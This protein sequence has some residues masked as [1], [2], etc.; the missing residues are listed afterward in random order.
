[1]KN[2]YLLPTEEP[3]RLFFADEGRELNLSKRANLYS[4]G[5]HL[6]ITS[7]EYIGLSY[8]LDDNLVRKGV[9]DD[10]RYWEVRK[11]Y[12]KIILTTDPKLIKDGVQAIDDEFLE[13]FVKNLSCEYV[14]VMDL[15]KDGE[16]SRHD[17]YQIIIS[18]ED[19]SDDEEEPKQETLE[20]VAQYKYPITKKGNLV[21]KFGLNFVANQAFKEGAKWQAER[22]YSEEE[23]LDIL[24][25]HTED[26]LAGKKLTLEEW[27]EQFKKK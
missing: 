16:S 23:V 1:M 10:R 11:D 7:D 12:K 15:W 9:I 19:H 25:K 27:F 20:E 17:S 3:S 14:D 18:E 2:I 21:E 8:Y 5:Q 24:Y 26:L 22:S 6:Y 4:T 13:W